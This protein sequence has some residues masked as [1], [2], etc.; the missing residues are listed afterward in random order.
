MARKRSDRKSA[1]TQKSGGSRAVSPA[2][3]KGA[4]LAEVTQ[5]HDLISKYAN[6]AGYGRFQLEFGEDSTGTPAVWVWF[7]VDDD[8]NPS[9]AK[10]S[11]AN[12][13]AQRIRSEVIRSGQGRWPYV[14]FRAAS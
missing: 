12:T 8:L 5:L 13:L 11:S 2:Q 3:Q 4:P 6:E 10:L 7:I 14:S 9:K 1:T